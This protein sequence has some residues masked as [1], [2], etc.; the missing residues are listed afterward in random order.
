MDIKEI[1]KNFANQTDL[2]RDNIEWHNILEDPF[3][4][5]GIFYSNENNCFLRMDDDIASQTNQGVLALNKDTAGGRV[6]FSTNSPF[7]TIYAKLHMVKRM[8]HMPLSGS[9]GF[10][11]YIDTKDESLYVGSFIPH[12][13]SDDSY[14]SISYPG[15][16][17]FVSGMES[18]TINFP[19]YS[20][21]KEL[22]IGVQKDSILKE[23]KKYEDIAPFV[24]YG[25]S[26]TQG[27]CASRPGNCYQNYI[28]R[29]FNIDYLN[30]GF[31]GSGRGE[32]IMAEYISSLNT[33]LFIMD[34]DHNAPNP[35]HLE[36]THYRFYEIYRKKQPNTPIIMISKPDTW[37]RSR[38][39]D[40]RTEIIYNSYLKAKNSGDKNVYFIDGSKF[41]VDDYKDSCTVDSI[42]PNDL[43]FYFMGKVIG[44]KIEGILKK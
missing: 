6:K 10:D 25:S 9:T 5:H 4:I 39:S 32:E 40:I 3:S 42:H 30:L 41:F 16:A 23:G 26:I 7:I 35:E 8:E 24:Y 31:S 11:L 28:V 15:C 21:V 33:S 12:L 22:Y 36:K 19:L 17:D 44:D 38:E 13:K 14:T 18:Y 43:G 2:G 29:R 20:G 1:D 37:T 34:Y 27:G